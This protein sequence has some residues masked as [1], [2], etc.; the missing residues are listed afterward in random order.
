MMASKSRQP[1]KQKIQK[2]IDDLEESDGSEYSD[3]SDDEE[4]KLNFYSF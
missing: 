2:F 1:S 4:G 3:I